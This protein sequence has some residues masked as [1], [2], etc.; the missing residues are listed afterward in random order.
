MAI[1]DARI[2]VRLPAL[3]RAQMEAQAARRGWTAAMY[4]REAIRLAL[5]DDQVDHRRPRTP[6]EPDRP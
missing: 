2:E 6:R 3:M 5:L 4:A 1:M